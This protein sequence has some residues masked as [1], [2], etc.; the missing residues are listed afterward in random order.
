MASKSAGT[1]SSAGKIAPRRYLGLE[2][3]GAKNPKTAIAALEYYPRERKIFL[4]DVYDR[5]LPREGQSTDEALIE[6]IGELSPGEARLGVNVPLTLPPCFDCS[7]KK[8]LDCSSASVKWVKELIRRTGKISASRGVRPLPFTP[9]TQRPIEAFVRYSI[10]PRLAEPLRFEIDETLGGNRAPLTARMHYLQPALKKLEPVEVWPKL[11]VVLFSEE[12]GL[13]KRVLQSYRQLESGVDA[14][15]EIL[16]RIAHSQG[17]FIYDRDLKKLAGSL[18]A[19]DSFIC[20]YTTLLCDLGLCQKA[21]PGFPAK[22]GWIAVPLAAGP[23]GR[24]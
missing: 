8:P 12:L 6:L 3:S 18:A 23:E 15:T 21:P 22:S 2:L 19:F 14:R 13:P 9:Y 5:V 10:L 17:V 16:E 24:R 20:A 1:E 7:C 4:L 11:A